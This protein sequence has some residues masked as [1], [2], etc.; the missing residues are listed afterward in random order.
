ML[1]RI[2]LAA[3]INFAMVFGIA[4]AGDCFGRCNKGCVTCP[5]CRHVCCQLNAEPVDE[6]KSCWKVECKDICVPRVVFP[7][8]NPHAK[9][10]HGLL[11]HLHGG[12]D[13]CCSSG[14]DSC[15]SDG[16]CGTNCCDACRCN[17]GACVKTVKVLKK[18]K[19]TC[20][21]CE[22]SWTPVGDCCGNGGACCDSGCAGADVMTEGQEPEPALAPPS[23]VPPAPPSPAD[24]TTSASVQQLYKN[25]IRAVFSSRIKVLKNR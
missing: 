4:T 9:K 19:Y 1:D 12:C 14:C 2:F 17:N 3:L 5:S 13:S 11:G 7:W 23:D 15:C 25:R 21:S 24:E 10:S 16:C 6:E 20:P 22:Y 8:Q 18:H